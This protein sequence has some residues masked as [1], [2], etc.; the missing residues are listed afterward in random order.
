MRR[1][2]RAKNAPVKL[3]TAAPTDRRTQSCYPPRDGGFPVFRFFVRP[4]KHP[5]NAHAHRKMASLTAR[6][7]Y[8]MTSFLTS[9]IGQRWKTAFVFVSKAIRK[10]LILREGERHGVAEL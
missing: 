3:L 5:K 8:S 7:G 1:E 2:K 4:Q 9:G 10:L 6:N